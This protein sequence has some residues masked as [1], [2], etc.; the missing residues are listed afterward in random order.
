MRSGS[1]SAH[2][3]CASHAIGLT[4]SALAHRGLGCAGR[5]A[6]GAGAGVAGRAQRRRARA[7]VRFELR[8][9]HLAALRISCA[10]PSGWRQA[11]R[12]RHERA[13]ARDPLRRPARGPNW[14]AVQRRGEGA[15]GRYAGPAL[16]GALGGEVARDARGLG[17][18]Q[19][20][21]ESADDAGAERAAVRG[22][23]RA[24]AAGRRS[25]SARS[26][27]RS[28][29]RG[30]PRQSA[31][32]P[33]AAGD[34]RRERGAVLDLVHAWVRRPGR[35]RVTS[36]EP[37]WLGVPSSRN[38]RGAVAGDQRE[39]GERLD[40]VDERRAA[41]DVRARTAAAG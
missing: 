36:G 24:S 5:G 18:R 34:Q 35:D 3:P 21:S 28:S 9:E 12:P 33:P 40:V 23:G 27:C 32:R 22:E 19:A 26:R 13:S 15:A 6:G 8:G 38:Q 16:A 30:A 4:R 14:R 7:R 31:V 10:A 1:S 29:R 25:R 39:V 20:S 17:D 41:A 37:G 11:P 2:M